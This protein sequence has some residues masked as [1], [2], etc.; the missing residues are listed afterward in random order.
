MNEIFFA[1]TKELLFCAF[2]VYVFECFLSE[3]ATV[4]FAFGRYVPP[5]GDFSVP[6]SN[7]LSQD[8]LKI[9]CDFIEKM[10]L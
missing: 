1:S 3:V 10:C 7:S 9:D 4:F 6:N 2:F 8:Y 5:N